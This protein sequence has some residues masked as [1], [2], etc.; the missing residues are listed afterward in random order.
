[1]ARLGG[2]TLEPHHQLFIK[3]FRFKKLDT[4]GATRNPPDLQQGLGR[5]TGTAEENALAILF[6]QHDTP[7]PG[8]GKVQT[9]AIEQFMHLVPVSQYPLLQQHT[10]HY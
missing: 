8:K 10:I 3:G 7:V 6:L 5:D 4:K 1:M 9:N 2:V